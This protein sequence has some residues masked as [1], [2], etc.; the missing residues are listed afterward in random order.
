ME[1]TLRDIRYGLRMLRKDLGFT[2][3]AVVA[4]MLAIASTTVIFSVINGVLLRPLP[5]PE[6]DRISIGP[7]RTM[8]SQRW[9]R[10]A[11]GR[12][13]WMKATRRNACA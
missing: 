2:I 8:F 4:L 13:I 12:E 9:Q 1:T 3:V 6:A 11:A 5:Y 10:R 7:R